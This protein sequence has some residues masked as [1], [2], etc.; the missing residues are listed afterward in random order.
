MRVNVQLISFKEDNINIDGL[1]D[2]GLYSISSYLDS[3][4]IHSDV[5]FTRGNSTDIVPII[6]Y[7]PDLVILS[8]YNIYPCVRDKFDDISGIRNLVDLLKTHIPGVSIAVAGFPVTYYW[9]EIM[10]SIP[11]I[12]YV[13]LGE[14]EETAYELAVMENVQGV[15]GIVY[16]NEADQLIKTERRAFISNMDLLPFPKR[17]YLDDAKISVVAIASSRGCKRAC[18][19]CS[20]P[21]FWGKWRCRSVNSVINEIQNIYDE[22]AIRKFNFIDESF[23]DGGIS[24]WV[25]L[26][27]ELLSRNIKISYFIQMRS[28]SYELISDEQLHILV[29][30]GLC[31]ISIGVETFNESDRMIYG[32]Y[33]SIQ[34]NIE[35]IGL[36]SISLNFKGQDTDR[37]LLR[38][39]SRKNFYKSRSLLLKRNSVSN[40][41]S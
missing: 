5:L 36:N 15:K 19:F 32:K 3:K 7:H 14:C 1:E 18:N 2:L 30:S 26:A 31:G 24:R 37:G 12:D 13:M 6:A 23:E 17:S 33:A 16:R 38:K 28:E 25:E 21:D 11:G 41:W 40:K 20:C 9:N 39:S 29:E 10:S 8:V 22:Y 35:C 27:N 34:Q 4:G